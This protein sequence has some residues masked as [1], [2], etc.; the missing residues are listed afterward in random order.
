M[1][2]ASVKF[3][4]SFRNLNLGRAPAP[5]RA[6]LESAFLSA[7]A[8]SAESFLTNG[9]LVFEANTRV[10]AERVLKRA[11]AVLKEGN[12]FQEP[13]FLRELDYL[14]ELVRRDPFASIDRA[15]VYE[16]CVTFF[17]KSPKLPSDPP[18]GNGRKDV[19]AVEYTPSE[20]MSAVYKVGASPGSPNAFIEKEFACTSTTRAWN[21][22]CRL[23]KKH[24]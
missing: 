18:G 22:V 20:F 23:V 12:G 14:V 10:N 6:Q 15:L 1:P 16:I 3:V 2:G 24:A 8:A 7:G 13:A 17:D 9:T 4:A 11:R 5:T 21:T 19:R